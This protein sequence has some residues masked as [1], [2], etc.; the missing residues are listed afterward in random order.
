[1]DVMANSLPEMA[2]RVIAASIWWW[3][4][5]KMRSKYGQSDLPE[6][7][8]THDSVAKPHLLN[9]NRPFWYSLAVQLL[10]RWAGIDERLWDK[11]QW[12]NGMNEAVWIFQ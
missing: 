11:S 8:H 3:W 6:S 12:L 9:S 1:M 2:E 7:I 4:D 5:P 10:N